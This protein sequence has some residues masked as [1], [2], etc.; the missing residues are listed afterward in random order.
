MGHPQVPTKLQFDNKCAHGILTG[1]LKQKKSKGMDMKFYWLHDISTEQKKFHTHWKR[2][3]HNLGDYP[4]KYHP[5][6]HHRTV[7]PLYVANEAT[8]FNKSFAT[9]INQLQSLCKGV[10]NL[11][12]QRKRVLQ[13]RHTKQID[14]KT[15]N[16]QLSLLGLENPIHST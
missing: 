2:G 4:T 1:V 11:N 3:N 15:R 6:K 9:A 12:P 10:L 5:A 7:R 13:N 16:Y 14:K 8:K